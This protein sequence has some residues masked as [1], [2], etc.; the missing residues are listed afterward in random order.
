MKCVFYVFACFITHKLTTRCEK[1]KKKKNSE[2]LQIKTT[3]PAIRRKY[4]CTSKA[5]QQQCTKP[6]IMARFNEITKTFKKFWL[7]TLKRKNI[8]NKIN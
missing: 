1:E 4:V 5:K 7:E 6:Y 3:R 2:M 8:I